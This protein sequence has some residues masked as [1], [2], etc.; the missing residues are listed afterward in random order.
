MNKAKSFSVLLIFILSLTIISCGPSIKTTGSWVNREKLPAEPVKSV[1]I[2]AFTDNIEARA[3]LEEDLALAA[4]KKG[5]KT[6][7]SMDVIGAVDIKYIAPVK[8]VFMKKLQALNCE[9]IFTV[10]LVN[11]ESETKYVPGTTVSVG[12]SP[13]SYGS[14]GGYGGYGPHSAYGGFGGYYSYA[15]STV[16]SPGYYQTDKKYFIE[17]KMFDL[18][19]EELLFSVQTEANNP[20]YIATSSKEYT[21]AVMKEIK[22]LNLQKK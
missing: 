8:E 15:V 21:A 3:Y 4:Q 16:G 12:Y 2:I 22:R 14:Y 6:Y 9:T 13:Y 7:K 1:F 19:T 20:A 17:A 10:A 5:L 11:S 18:K